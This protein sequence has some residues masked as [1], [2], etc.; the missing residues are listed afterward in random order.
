MS[1]KK[2]LILKVVIDKITV[3]EGYY[4]IKYHY[5]INGKGRKS[6]YDSDYEGWTIK[7]W[8]KT[9]E[10]GEAMRIVLQDIT[11]CY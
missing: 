9:L 10:K 2:E 5:S 1:M 7:E 8:T 11:D 6:S 3:E 4:D